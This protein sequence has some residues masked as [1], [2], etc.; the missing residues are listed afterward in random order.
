MNGCQRSSVPKTIISLVD[1]AVTAD[2]V[3]VGRIFEG[4]NRLEGIGRE[5]D[6]TEISVLR[7]SDC[8]AG[9][10]REGIIAKHLDLHTLILG[11]GDEIVDHDI[12]GLGGDG[13]GGGGQEDKGQK[14]GQHNGVKGTRVDMVPVYQA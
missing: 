10:V 12:W 3:Q 14:E 2:K 6:E 8:K 9:K 11:D 5:G 1:N 4:E 7:Y 13:R